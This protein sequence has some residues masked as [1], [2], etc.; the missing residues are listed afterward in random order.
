MIPGL[1]E[2]PTCSVEVARRPGIKLPTRQSPKMVVCIPIGPKDEEFIFDLPE[3][4]EC[5]REKCE[6][7]WHGKK[8]YRPARNQGLVSFEWATNHMQ[9][10]VPLGTTVGYLA[11]KG[12]LSGPARNLMTQR[13]LELD[14]EYIFYWDDDVIL[15]QH[16]FYSMCNAMERYPDIGLLSG[17]V[18]TR[19]DPP[20]PMVYRRQ[21]DGAWWNFSIDPNAEPETIWAAGG[22]CLLARAS[23]VRQMEDPY[24]ADVHG[25]HDDPTKPGGSVWGHDIYFCTKLAQASGMRVAV[26]G[27]VLC[28]HFDLEKQ[29]TYVLPEDSPPYRKL[30]APK[31]PPP[32]TVEMCPEL[33]EDYVDLQLRSSKHERRIFVVPKGAQSQEAIADVL[34]RFF[35]GVQLSDGDEN[36]VAV[37]R[38]LKNGRNH[39]EPGSEPR[40]D[41]LGSTGS[42]RSGR[43]PGHE[44]LDCFADG[45][46]EGPGAP[47]LAPEFAGYD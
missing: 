41:Q 4:G 33:T 11:E 20:E 5:G 2:N 27:S 24:W 46:S 22:G 30:N 40:T 16:T 8:L 45:S 43:G 15:P 25:A 39:A 3:A 31:P 29:K 17:V 32:L 26:M 12:K 10:I 21:G 44:P 7:P 18:V 42:D 28:G 9:L 6:C 1:I 38:G 47:A 23:A 34:G 36:W 19:H 37:T 14:P 13:A 35:T